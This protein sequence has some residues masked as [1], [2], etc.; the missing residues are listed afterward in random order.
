MRL[1]LTNILISFA[2]YPFY[3]FLFDIVLR[4]VLSA[5]Y[6]FCILRVVI[7][8]RFVC[9][10]P[11]LYFA[12]RFALLLLL[13]ASLYSVIMYLFVIVSLCWCPSFLF[14]FLLLFRSCCFLCCCFVFVT[15][16]FNPFNKPLPTLRIEY[17]QR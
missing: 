15:L 10:V 7:A 5:L 13:F 1:T 8:C 16:P 3:L 9:V 6:P 2:S 12:C 14:F 17:Y 4:V 11:V